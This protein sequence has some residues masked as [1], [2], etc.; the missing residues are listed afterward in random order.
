[1]MSLII[2]NVVMLGVVLNVVILSVTMSC[3]IMLRVVILNVVI[4]NVVILSA[5]I[6]SV[7]APF[8]VS[9]VPMQKIKI[10]LAGVIKLF[11]VAK[12][13]ICS[14]LARF[15]SFIGTFVYFRE[16]GLHY[17]TL[18]DIILIPQCSQYL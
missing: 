18:I 6:L 1:M 10:L 7:T 3:V 4:L 12:T 11:S 17:N 5:V 14:K 16:Q 15:L 8:E 2:P 13:S 9:D